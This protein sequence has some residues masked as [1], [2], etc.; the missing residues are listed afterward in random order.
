M[1]NRPGAIP[2]QLVREMM[3][4]G[5]IRDADTAAIQPSSLDLTVTNE[6]YRLRGSYLPRPGERVEDIAKRPTVSRE[7][8][9]ELAESCDYAKRRYESF[10]QV[11]LDTARELLAAVEG[12]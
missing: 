8:V 2:Y 3:A 6:V 4:S 12:K 1:V 9:Q 7:A 5:Y 11:T 10:A